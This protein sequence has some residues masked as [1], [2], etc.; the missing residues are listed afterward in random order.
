MTIVGLRSA[1]SEPRRLLSQSIPAQNVPARSAHECQVDG[2]IGL[3]IEQNVAE[4]KAV[5]PDERKIGLVRD[6]CSLGRQFDARFERHLGHLSAFGFGN[7]GLFRRIVEK[8][9]RGDDGF[10]SGFGD[11]YV[12]AR[13]RIG[14]LAG[15][16]GGR[17]ERGQHLRSPGVV[18]DGRYVHDNPAGVGDSDARFLSLVG[19][20]RKLLYGDGRRPDIVAAKR[21]FGGDPKHGAV[22][23]HEHRDPVVGDGFFGRDQHHAIDGPRGDLERNRQGAAAEQEQAGDHRKTFEHEIPLSNCSDAGSASFGVT[24]RAD[25]F[26]YWRKVCA[27]Y[28]A[29]AK[30]IPGGIARD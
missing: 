1:I 8:H 5:A 18:A 16:P 21:P 25:F 30:D 22:P 13:S 4:V 24:R 7:E 27:A 17:L 15:R 10:P 20:R 3:K 11:G 28:D 12:V 19:G 29:G 9:G 23:L 2:E 6:G 14:W 26:V